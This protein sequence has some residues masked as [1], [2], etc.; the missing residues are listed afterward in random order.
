[1]GII[2]LYLPDKAVL[3]LSKL[4]EN[5]VDGH[6]YRRFYKMWVIS[7]RRHPHLLLYLVPSGETDESDFV[8]LW[9]TSACMRAQLLSH[10]WLCNPMNYSSPGSSL[11]GI[12]QARILQ[13]VAISFSRGSSQSRDQTHNSCLAGGFFT[14]EP[15]GKPHGVHLRLRKMKT[16][17]LISRT[18]WRAF[19]SFLQLQDPTPGLPTL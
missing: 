17:K 19:P 4:V 12:L 10:V 7:S 1:M 16:E 14:T 5:L 11:H 8:M 13:W 9:C 6:H 3:G 18:V 15:P 2:T